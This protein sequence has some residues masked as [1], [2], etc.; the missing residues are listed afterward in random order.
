MSF[1]SRLCDSC[2]W[3]HQEVSP[4]FWAIMA[5]NFIANNMPSPAQKNGGNSISPAEIATYHRDGYVMLNLRL[6]QPRMSELGA[7]VEIL[8]ETNPYVPP[9]ALM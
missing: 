2:H 1:R 7:A 3:G 6:S 8:L 5:G 4:R 9:E